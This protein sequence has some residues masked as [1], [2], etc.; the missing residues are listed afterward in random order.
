MNYLAHLAVNYNT[1]F[2]F[3]LF[4][5]KPREFLPVKIRFYIF[6]PSVAVIAC[7]LPFALLHRSPPL[8]ALLVRFR[9]NTTHRQRRL[10]F[11]RCTYTSKYWKFPSF[12]PTIR[13]A[14][15]WRIFDAKADMLGRFFQRP[16]DDATDLSPSPNVGAPLARKFSLL[17]FQQFFRLLTIVPLGL[18]GQLCLVHII[19]ALS[20]CVVEAFS[21]N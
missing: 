14:I 15:N 9:R 5:R 19:L 8:V 21:V 18:F 16:R 11:Y 4:S 7:L 13:R 1:Q 17:D 3:F 20:H 12:L 2:G 6:L 10:Y